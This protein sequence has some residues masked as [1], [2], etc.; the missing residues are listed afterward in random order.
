MSRPP[1]PLSSFLAAV[2]MAIF[3]VLLTHCA[4]HQASVAEQ[5]APSP[6][7]NTLVVVGFFPAVS[8]GTEPGVVRGPL[9]G[10]VHMAYPV[11]QEI[12]DKM[13]ERLVSSLAERKEYELISPDQAKG[14]LATILSSNPAVDEAR[15]M[16]EVGRSLSAD[17]VL[18]GY[19]YRWLEREGTDYAAHRPA[20]VAFDLYLLRTADGRLLWKGNFDRSQRSLTENLLEFDFFV[21]GKGKWMT[22]DALGDMGLSDMMERFPRAKGAP[23]EEDKP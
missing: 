14:A 3:S 1:L 8:P 4:P 13:N 10:A 12:I 9:S 19:V 7:G 15:L 6:E 17:S 20:S 21:K 22:A 5:V 11:P 16:T 18:L 2:T 23:K